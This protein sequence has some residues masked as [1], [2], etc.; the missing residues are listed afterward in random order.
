MSNGNRTCQLLINKYII[1]NRQQSD[2]RLYTVEIK[3]NFVQCYRV[4][5]VIVGL[6]VWCHWCGAVERLYTGTV[7]DL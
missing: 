1:V 4:Q 6:A 5:T 2:R 7:T 3:K